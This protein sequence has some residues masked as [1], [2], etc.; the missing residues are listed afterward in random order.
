MQR[1]NFLIRISSGAAAALA[2]THL[3]GCFSP[4]E[5]LPNTPVDF[6]LDL[7]QLPQLT[8]TS[9]FVIKDNVLVARTFQGDYVAATV[10]CSHEQRKEIV[11]E[12]ERNQF[13]C[14]AHDARFDA[15]GKGL[16]KEGNKNLTVYN[17]TV[18]GNNLRIFS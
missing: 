5:S 3:T 6:T 12:G 11:F 10:I 9:G 15:S 2:A 7:S 16:N 8:K 17:T 14:T 1:R 13:H 18:E 4:S